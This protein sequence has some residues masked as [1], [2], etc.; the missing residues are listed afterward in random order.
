MVFRTPVHNAADA[1]TALGAAD[2]NKGVRLY[3]VSRDEQ[4]GHVISRFV[5]LQNGDGDQ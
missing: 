2:L 4:T 1:A 3:V 5:F